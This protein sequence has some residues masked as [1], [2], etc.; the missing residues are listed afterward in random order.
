MYYVAQSYLLKIIT[1]D[2]IL[3]LINEQYLFILYITRNVNKNVDNRLQTIY[4]EARFT[5]SDLCHQWGLFKLMPIVNLVARYMSL[6]NWKHL[7]YIRGSVLFLFLTPSRQEETSLSRTACYNYFQLI[8][9]LTL[10]LVTEI[11]AII[12]SRNETRLTEI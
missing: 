11:G 4:S 5:N 1:S 3:S 2:F 6:V 9:N 10:Q 8:P 12:W 7:G